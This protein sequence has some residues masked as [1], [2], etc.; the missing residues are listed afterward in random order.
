MLPADVRALLAKPSELTVDEK[1]ALCLTLCDGGGECVGAEELRDLFTRGTRLVAYD[2]FEPSGGMHVAQGL[3]KAHSVRVLRKCGIDVVFWVADVFAQLNGKLGGDMERIRAAGLRMI[4]T[5]T[6]LGCEARYLWCSDETNARPEDY[7][8]MVM[9]VACN[10]SLK[11]VLRCT[12]V[13]GRSDGDALSAGQV[14]Y[15]VMQ[16]ADVMFLKVDICQMGMDQRKVNMLAREY[17]AHKPVVLSHPMLPGLLRGQAKMSKSDPTSAIFMHDSAEAVR[18]KIAKAY[19][20]PGDPHDNPCLAYARH[21]V[22]PW[23]AFE[24]ETSKGPMAFD[25]Y[26]SLQEAYVAG[27]VHPKELKDGLTRSLNDLLSLECVRGA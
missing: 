25:D 26:A 23:R 20:P 21:L 7:W 17:C 12:Q 16:V 2:G 4:E 18:A 6:A 10:T 9:R 11:R 1:V 22:L 5:W 15:P 24:V 19:C 14:M 13:M 3:M 27:E 8:A